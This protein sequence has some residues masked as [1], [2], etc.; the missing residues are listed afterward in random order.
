MAAAGGHSPALSLRAMQ[1]RIAWLASGR[2]S[3][4][5][6]TSRR[7]RSSGAGE[8]GGQVPGGG[9]GVEPGFRQGRGGGKPDVVGVGAGQERAGPRQQ[10]LS[11]GQAGVD[12]GGLGDVGVAVADQP[13]QDAVVAEPTGQGAGGAALVGVGVGRGGGQGLAHVGVVPTAGHQL[14]QEHPPGRV[15]SAA[16]DLH[17]RPA[18][19]HFRGS[20]G[21]VELVQRL[22]SPDQGLELAVRRARQGGGHAVDDGG[23]VF[24]P[25]DGLE[26]G[27]VALV[28]VGA[29]HLADERGVDVP[30]QGEHGR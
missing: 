6:T 12:E 17:R 1:S 24:G 16:G 18:V 25:F 4:A 22:Q 19:V 29:V 8:Q 10:R 2:G 7:S 28:G 5:R 21:H 11:P 23:V 15:R 26:D 3:P 13:G 30:R 9:V 27:E 14:D 20:A